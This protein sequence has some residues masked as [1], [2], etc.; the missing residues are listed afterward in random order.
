M[1]TKIQLIVSHPSGVMTVERTLNL[2]ILPPLASNIHAGTDEFN[3]QSV[4]LIFKDDEE[5]YFLIKAQTEYNRA[6]MQHL[7]SMIQRLERDGWS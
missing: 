5:P 1:F 7:P 6:Q 3:V 2:P 4:D